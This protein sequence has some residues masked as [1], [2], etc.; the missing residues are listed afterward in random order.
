MFPRGEGG[1]WEEVGGGG[2]QGKVEGRGNSLLI[3]PRPHG[4]RACEI[5]ACYEVSCWYA[6]LVAATI[7]LGE[8]CWL[9]LL[10]GYMLPTTAA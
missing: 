2:R 7:W 5:C 8:S 3:L 1:S 4:G 9:V 6:S 10:P